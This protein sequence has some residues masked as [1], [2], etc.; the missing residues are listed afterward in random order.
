MKIE[1]GDDH[2]TFL[3]SFSFVSNWA[4]QP[5]DRRKALKIFTE[6]IAPTFFI[7]YKTSKILHN[8]PAAL[9]NIQKNMYL[10]IYLELSMLSLDEI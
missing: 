8:M 6:Q 2:D 1:N 5:L 3:F 4:E 10:F 7:L 9:H